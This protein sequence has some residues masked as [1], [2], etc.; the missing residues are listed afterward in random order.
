MNNQNNNERPTRVQLYDSNNNRRS[1]LHKGGKKPKMPHFKGKNRLFK[2]LLAILLV[3]LVIMIIVFLI[4]QQNPVNTDNN[5]TTV[6]TSSKSSSHKKKHH[7]KHQSSST[8]NDDQDT[9]SFSYSTNNG[10]GSR[11]TQHYSNQD[12]H[13]TNNNGGN[14]SPL[15]NLAPHSQAKTIITG[16]LTNL[17]IPVIVKLIAEIMGAVLV[18][19]QQQI[20]L[21]IKKFKKGVAIH[22]PSDIIIGN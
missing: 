7:K 8:S 5:D 10:G 13:P 18:L 17:A 21:V 16:T 6:S 3:I 9:Y 2:I 14:T 22:F 11:G 15:L 4:K 1:H 19:R 20:L 12:Q